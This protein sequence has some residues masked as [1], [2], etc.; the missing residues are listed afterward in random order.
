MIISLIRVLFFRPSKLVSLLGG[1]AAGIHSMVDEHFG[2]SVVEY[3]AAGAIPIG[4]CPYL[5]LLLFVCF[6]N[7][8]NCLPSFL[9]N[10]MA[11]S[12]PLSAHNSAGP[13]MD[14]VLPE[15]GKQTGFL[16]QTLEEYADAIVSIIRMPASE[17]L[18]MAAAAR[19]RASQ[20]SEQRFYQDFKSAVRPIMSNTTR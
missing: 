4:S 20:F 10:P 5:T 3:M 16:A 2:I 12:I 19:K 18:E 8:V 17:R 11:S 13:R 15:D 9:L 6:S 14:I 1:A 7:H